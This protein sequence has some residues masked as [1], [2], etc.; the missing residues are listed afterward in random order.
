M[1]IR[2]TPPLSL[3]PGINSV[4]ERTRKLWAKSRNINKG[5]V[6]VGMENRTTGQETLPFT[7]TLT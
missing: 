3:V 6:R 2:D 1:G 7:L 5:A 4:K